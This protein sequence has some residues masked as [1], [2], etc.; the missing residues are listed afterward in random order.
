MIQ[1]QSGGE[2]N[3]ATARSHCATVAA[4]ADTLPALVVAAM[5][6]RTVRVTLRRMCAQQWALTVAAMRRRTVRVTGTP[7]CFASKSL[8]LLRRPFDLPP[9]LLRPDAE[10][11]GG[12]PG[13]E[14]FYWSAAARRG[15]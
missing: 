8:R 1:E 11:A 12:E 6:R 5:R 2:G 15:P 7:S 3:G 13:R 4:R 10:Q 14:Q 9:E